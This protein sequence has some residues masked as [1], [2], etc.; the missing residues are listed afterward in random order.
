MGVDAFLGEAGF[1]R[2]LYLALK[3]VRK[4]CESTVGLL[5]AVVSIPVSV[6]YYFHKASDVSVE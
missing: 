1:P 4:R 6:V 3:M 5:S 2:R